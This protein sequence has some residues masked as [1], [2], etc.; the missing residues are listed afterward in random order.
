MKIAIVPISPELFLE[1]LH[2]P[3]DTRLVGADVNR[4]GQ[5]EVTLEHADLQEQPEGSVGRAEPMFRRD[6]AGVVRFLEW[7]QK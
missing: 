6:D 3:K 1:A 5:L 7:N 4:Y 2:L